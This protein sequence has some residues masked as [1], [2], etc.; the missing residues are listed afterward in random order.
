MKTLL[1]PAVAGLNV[2][3]HLVRYLNHQ[4]AGSRQTRR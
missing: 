2:A 1:T 4:M 3:R